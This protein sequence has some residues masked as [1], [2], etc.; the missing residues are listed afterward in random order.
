VP[1]NRDNDFRLHQRRSRKIARISRDIL[2][3]Y[4]LTAG[5]GRAA[6]SGV[7][8]NASFRRKAAGE[9][10][11]D[12]VARIRRI[13]ELEACPV[14]ARHLFVKPLGNPLHDGLDRSGGLGVVLKFKEKFFM[15]WRHVLAL[16]R[17]VRKLWWRLS[18]G[19]CPPLILHERRAPTT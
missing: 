4:H 18:T 5:G 14:V 9:R 1:I 15:Y 13:D 2:H 16:C 7:E 12:E 6:E 17:R 3:H 19:L 10:S 11:D 8:G